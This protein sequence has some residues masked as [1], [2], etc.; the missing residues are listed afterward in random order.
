MIKNK[1][2]LFLIIVSLI[3]P[4]TAFAE[5]MQ[6]QVI[7]ASADT[8][9]VNSDRCRSLN[10]GSSSTMLFG[11]VYQRTAMLKFDLNGIDLSAYKGALLEIYVASE[12]TDVS[13]YV[14]STDSDW[15]ENTLTW[16]NANYPMNFQASVPI[17]ETGIKKYEISLNKAFDEA[18]NSDS[19]VLSLSFSSDAKCLSAYSSEYHKQ[20]MRPRLILTES[21]AFVI[22]QIDVQYTRPTPQQIAADIRENLATKTHPYIYASKEDF[23]EI[24]EYGFGKDEFLTKTYSGI[25][26]KADEYLTLDVLDY[27]NEGLDITKSERILSTAVNA[28]ERI[29]FLATV[30]NV[31]NDIQYAERAWK[32]LDHLVSQ[33]HWTHTLL[34]NS[35]ACVAASI[36]YDWLYDYLGPERREKVVAAIKSKSLDIITDIYT[37]PDLYSTWRNPTGTTQTGAVFN[38][39]NHSSHNNSHFIVGALAVADT[40]PDYSAYIVSNALSAAEPMMNVLNPDGGCYEGTGY[41]GY[42]GSKF[43]M[44]FAAM[45]SALGTMYGYDKVPG[46]AKTGYFPIYMQS[47]YGNM[48]Y[49]DM[50]NNVKTSDEEIFFLAMMS[51]DKALQKLCVDRG[52][53]GAFIAMWYDVEDDF[54]N[55]EISLTLDK[56]FRNVDAISMRDTWQGQQ[57][58]FTGFRTQQANVSHNDAG[59]GG[60]ALDAFG[61]RWV[62][63][64]GKENYDLPNYW[65]QQTQKGVRWTYYARRPEANNCVV[66]NPDGDVGQIVSAR[67]EIDTFI[68]KERG[69]IANSDLT[70]AYADDAKSYTRAVTLFNDRKA[71]KV[72]DEIVMHKP[73]EVYWFMNINS[74]DITISEDGKSVIAKKN[75]KMLHTAISANA[76]FEITV[77]NSEPL[78]TSPNPD[79][80][81]KFRETRKIA[82]HFKDVSDLNI[83]AVLTP[84]LSEIEIPGEEPEF[85]PIKDWK[86]PDGELQRIMLDSITANGKEIDGFNPYNRF[87]EITSESPVKDLNIE[88]VSSQYDCKTV[89]NAGNTAD[90]I[91]SR[92]DNPE[93]FAVYRILVKAEA[94]S[95]IDFDKVTEIPIVS[96]EATDNDG[97]IPENAIDGNLASR[98]SAAGEPSIIFD[99]GSKQKLNAIGIA[100]YSGSKRKAYFEIYTSNDGVEWTYLKECESS[101][102]SEEF[103]YQTLDGVECRYVKYSGYGTNQDSWNSIRDVKIYK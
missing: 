66:I 101:G 76:D 9:I 82:V 97:N 49:N 20:I 87:Y 63:G 51:G 37:N 8:Y 62:T 13:M 32:E 42:I 30:Y 22:G 17:S 10:Y 70:S 61:E 18:K 98:W 96:V 74:K 46:I 52:F 33:N 89:Y 80:Q 2:L 102:E 60:F 67:P 47:S 94:K 54:S 29:S 38:P 73:S 86:I 6:S 59:S 57:E 65:D 64:L 81:T 53:F 15:S 43:G 16:N 25:K 99:L 48:V 19:K 14:Y 103:E 40:D 79:G 12:Q 50:Y 24:K 28:I 55:A 93:D 83:T 78:P 3:L 11:S 35:S 34:D 7:E 23:E 4:H 91:V 45:Q 36:G 44:A 95:V 31:E 85:I 77:M 1:L 92:K 56:Q 72:Q 39:M 26:K 100:F 88:G 90:V 27:G 68:T 71:Y 58:I 5:D 41:W 69:S 75:G 21:E 84:I